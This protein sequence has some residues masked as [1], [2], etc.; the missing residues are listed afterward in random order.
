[1]R[2]LIYDTSISALVNL[3]NVKMCVIAGFAME[4]I[5]SEVNLILNSASV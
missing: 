5:K 1:M 2:S 3:I 4:I